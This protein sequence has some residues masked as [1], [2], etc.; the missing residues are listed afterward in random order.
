MKKN[1]Y[2]K[3]SESKNPPK[4]IWRKVSAKKKL[5]KEYL[6]KFSGEKLSLIKSEIF[7]L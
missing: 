6:Q 1:N 3:I 5:E 2:K 7:F 4:N